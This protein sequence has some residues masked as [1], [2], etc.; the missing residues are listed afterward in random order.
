MTAMASAELAGWAARYATSGLAVIPLHSIRDGACTCRWADCKSPGKHPLTRNGKDDAT[1]D[2][3][4]VTAWWD[5]WSWANIGIRPPSGVI[6]LDVDPRNGGDTALLALARQHAL[7][8][9]TL[10]AGTGSGGLHIWLA[11]A[12]PARGQL[13]RGVDIKTER[14]YVV[15]PPSL[16][17]SGRRYE[18]LVGMP[19][20]P[21]P[22]WVRRLL[23]PA[24]ASLAPHRK[25]AGAGAGGAGL[26]RVVAAAGEGQRNTLLNW[27][28]YH[29][30]QR[31]GDP[32]LLAEI[33]GAALSA[34]LPAGEVDKTIA[35]AARAVAR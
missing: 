3:T 24:P 5:R 14:G 27:A 8:P 15:A 26:A 2:L 21:A 10:T 31:G 30:Y 4:R 34:G 25:A 32:A 19:T 1:T 35:S 11:Y 7:L 9:R 12:G 6:V 20:A 17:A 22:R 33:R 23:N 29:A 16:H 18:W 28:A 13:C